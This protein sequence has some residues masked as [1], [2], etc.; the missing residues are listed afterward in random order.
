MRKLLI[1]CNLLLCGCASTSQPHQDDWFGRDKVSHFIVS[2]V[3]GAGTTKIAEKNGAGPCQA[4]VIGVSVSLAIG[5]GKEFYDKNYK[6]TFFSWR[7]MA[8]NL[9][10]AAVGSYAVA[11]C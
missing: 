11:E 8:W 9:A 5:V 2:A 3:V 4:P 7:D 6:K 1:L 10:G